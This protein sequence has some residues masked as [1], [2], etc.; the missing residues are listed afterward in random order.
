MKDPKA[1]FPILFVS[2]WIGDL[3][4]TV[5]AFFLAFTHEGPLSPLVFLTVA[6]CI[7]AGNLLPIGAYLLFTRFREAELRAEAVEA[8]VRVREALRRSEEVVGRLDEAEG[9]LS[10]GILVARQVPERI[11]DK[12]ESV[13]RLLE[14]L[15]TLEV[16]SFA[17]AMAAQGE[18]LNGLKEESA[19]A[20]KSLDALKRE[21][22]GLPRKIGRQIKESV[23][24]KPAP[25]SGEEDVSIGEQLDLVY[26]SLESVQDS[27]DS[28]LKRVIELPVPAA[29]SGNPP[30]PEI[31]QPVEE[32]LEEKVEEAPEAGGIPEPV[33]E[34]A[35]EAAEPLPAQAEMH[36]GGAETDGPERSEPALPADRVQLNVRAMVGLRNKLYIRG[37]EPWLS[38]DEGRPMEL[39]GIG[40]YVWS[41]DDLKEPIDVAVLLNDEVEAAGGPVRLDPGKAVTITPLFPPSGE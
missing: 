2:S 38:W 26:E 37:D 16:E 22:E 23:P 13:E 19:T 36:L 28:L 32:Q 11:S 9:A 7:L 15:E 31:K 39:V 24:D 14:K 21:L 8:D 25:E 40:E 27:L 29:A 3:L 30:K 35:G 12:M 5:L 4:L 41:M 33:D 17:A 34:E 1:L 10:K 6:L 20:G 18:A